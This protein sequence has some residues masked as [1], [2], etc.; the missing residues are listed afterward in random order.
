MKIRCK[1]LEFVMHY[2]VLSIFQYLYAWLD[3]VGSTMSRGVHT[4]WV[5]PTS[6]YCIYLNHFQRRVLFCV[7]SYQCDAIFSIT[8]W[9]VFKAPFNSPRPS[10]YVSLVYIVF[11]SVYEHSRLVR[12][13]LEHA[14]LIWD[15]YYGVHTA[16][17]P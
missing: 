7:V 13:L 3:L 17:V 12:P 9:V 1:L 4:T 16:Q 2:C 11:F 8:H 6:P 14:C 5:M 15:P 10:I